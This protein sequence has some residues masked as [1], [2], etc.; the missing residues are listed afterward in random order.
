MSGS[1]VG[2]SVGSTIGASVCASVYN[3]TLSVNIQLDIFCLK[4]H[5]VDNFQ[6]AYV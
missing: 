4:L 1:S 6:R 3:E 2:T 5:W